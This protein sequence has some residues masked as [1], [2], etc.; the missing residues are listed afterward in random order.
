MAAF[1]HDY[2]SLFLGTTPLHIVRPILRSNPL[3]V[4]GIPVLDAMDCFIPLTPIARFNE[5]ESPLINAM[6]IR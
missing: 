5:N 1:L 4:V 3:C 2:L 6:S